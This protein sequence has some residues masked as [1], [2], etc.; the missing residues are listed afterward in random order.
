MISGRRFPARV[1]Q[2]RARVEQAS[3][4]EHDSLLAYL[5]RNALPVAGPDEPADTPN[6]ELFEQQCATCH[7]LPSPQAHTADEWGVVIARMQANMAMMD[8][9][10]LSDDHL[11]RLT[12]Y[13]TER[14]GT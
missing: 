1:G 9:P 5:Q 11:Q 2:T 3:E 10:T 7:Q 14:S 8:V 6:G 13:L 12:R 4:S